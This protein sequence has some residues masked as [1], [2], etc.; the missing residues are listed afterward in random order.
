MLE[1]EKIIARVDDLTPNQYTK[2]QKLD[3][4]DELDRKIDVELRKTHY[5][6]E[7]EQLEN[8]YHDEMYTYWLQAKIALQNAEIAKYNQQITMFN[9]EY[10]EFGSWVNRKY[11]PKQPCGGNR[12]HF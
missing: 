11:F 2:Q 1:T 9:S 12:F 3:W 5:I 4:I 8:P 6:P 7:G 10:S